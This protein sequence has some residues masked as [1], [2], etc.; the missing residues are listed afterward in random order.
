[1]QVSNPYLL[2]TFFAKTNHFHLHVDIFCSLSIQSNFK[3]VAG[4]TYGQWDYEYDI[5][6]IKDTCTTFL[7]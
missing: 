3:L 7:D 4:F 5:I 2:H 1:M 6:T